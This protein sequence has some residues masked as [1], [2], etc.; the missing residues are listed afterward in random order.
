MTFNFQSIGRLWEAADAAER[1]VLLMQ[2]I[3]EEV[4]QQVL[5]SADADFDADF[6][7]EVVHRCLLLSA[8]AGA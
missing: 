4:I 7:Y 8:D 6:M 2:E 1:K 5:S 3:R